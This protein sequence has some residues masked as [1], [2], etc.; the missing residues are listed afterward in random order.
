MIHK[1]VILTLERFAPLPLQESYDNS[2]LQVGLTDVET[3]GVLLCLDVTEEVLQEAA[4]LGCNLVVSHHPLLFHSL[5]QVGGA[6]LS[7]RCV[8]EAI[9]KGLTLYAAH[10]NLDNTAEGVNKMMAQRLGLKRTTFLSE[11]EAGNPAAGGSGLIG[12]LPE[13]ENAKDFL[14]RVKQLFNASCLMHNTLLSRPIK[15]VALCGGSGDFLLPEAIEKD[16]DAFLTGEMHYHQYFGAD[17]V[18]QIGV[19]GHYESEQFTQE[20]LREIIQ[21]D[22][23]ALPLHITKIKTNPINYL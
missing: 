16:A 10:T 7:E 20:L 18:I 23:P 15:R 12:E 22:F 3:S 21:R 2:G 13:A 9:L 14:L 1:D 6:T 11:K 5:K 19:M 17:N 4:A 8:R